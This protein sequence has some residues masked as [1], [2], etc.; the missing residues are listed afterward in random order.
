MVARIKDCI[1]QNAYI[2]T[3]GR[4]KPKSIFVDKLPVKGSVC[5]V[6]KAKFILHVRYHAP[7]AL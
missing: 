1:I 3:S 7:H 2:A 4:E 5:N 6:S